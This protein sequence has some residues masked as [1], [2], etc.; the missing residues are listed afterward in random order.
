MPQKKKIYWTGFHSEKLSK[1]TTK[2]KTQLHTAETQKQQQ[3]DTWRA[4][5]LIQLESIKSY[6]A[7]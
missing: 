5:S 1:K 4:L 6:A 7:N 3:A 2:S